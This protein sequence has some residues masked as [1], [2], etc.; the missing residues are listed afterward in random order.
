M[1][2]KMKS[3][4]G[5]IIL[6]LANFA[7]SFSLEGLSQRITKNGIEV[8]ASLLPQEKIDEYGICFDIYKTNSLDEYCTIATN[9]ACREFYK[10]SLNFFPE[11]QNLSKKNK[12]FIYNESQV[13]LLYSKFICSGIDD[14]DLEEYSK[15]KYNISE[16]NL[17]QIFLMQ[18]QQP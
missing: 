15:S 12:E 6:L 16:K 17:Y 18:Q 14:N 8:C 13:H 7:I 5:F 2:I 10:N 4:T 3:I 1:Q 11:C 9:K